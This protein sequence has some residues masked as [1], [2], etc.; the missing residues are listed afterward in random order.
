ML[1][2]W[3]RTPAVLRGDRGLSTGSHGAP[4]WWLWRGVRRALGQLAGP[5]PSWT[6]GGKDNFVADQ[7]VAGQ[8]AAAYP[9]VLVA[10]RGR[11]SRA[12][13]LRVTVASSG[14]RS[15]YMSC[16]PAGGALAR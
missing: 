2:S 7:A 1:L 6:L 8:A 15:W 16:L 14:I 9:D 13:R 3:A 10:V 4:K 12:R 11:G 5:A